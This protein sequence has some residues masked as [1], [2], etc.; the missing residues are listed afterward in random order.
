MIKKIKSTIIGLS[1]ISSSL[2]AGNIEHEQSNNSLVGVELGYSSVDYEYGTELNNAQNKTSLPAGGIKVGAES[3]NYRAFISGRYFYDTSEDYDYITTYGVEVQ[4]KFNPTN[5]FNVFI[6]ANAG[7][8][9]LKWRSD[10]ETFSRTISTSYFG[11]DI[12]MNLHLGKS[13]DWEVG[14]RVM[15]LNDTNTI[16]NTTYRVNT[17][18]TAYTSIIFKWKM[19]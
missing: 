16:N 6:G 11:G 18:I 13:V 12:G 17:I 10:S 2:L 15:S 4:Y 3:E 9:N 14:G 8:A 1:I 7:I 19:D 5:V